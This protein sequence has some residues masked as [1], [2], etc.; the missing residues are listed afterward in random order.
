MTARTGEWAAGV[1][2]VALVALVALLSCTT[3]SCTT[4]GVP[5]TSDAGEGSGDDLSAPCHLEEPLPATIVVTTSTGGSLPC[6]AT[7]SVLGANG[8]T[9]DLC[10][11]VGNPCEVTMVDSGV[12]GCPYS[13]YVNGASSPVT[14]EVSQPGFQTQKVADV[15]DGLGGCVPDPTAASQSTVML[16]P[17]VADAG[18]KDAP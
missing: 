18:T 2:R 13:F 10:G 3:S 1:A 16:A 14:V 8:A 15:F 17:A 12:S 5:G 7:I 6:D 4:S 9:T 11:D